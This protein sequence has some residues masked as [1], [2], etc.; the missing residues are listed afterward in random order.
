[1]DA[2]LLSPRT[3]LASADRPPQAWYAVARRDLDEGEELTLNYFATPLGIAKPAAFVNDRP[4]CVAAYGAALPAY[5]EG[6]W[7]EG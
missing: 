5:A 1:M 7:G 3:T 2:D 6:E 4:A